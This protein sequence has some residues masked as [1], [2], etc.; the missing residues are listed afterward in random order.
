MD[1]IEKLCDDAYLPLA[2]ETRQ[3][4]RGFLPGKPDLPAPFMS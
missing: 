3:Q 1:Y 4:N 2:G